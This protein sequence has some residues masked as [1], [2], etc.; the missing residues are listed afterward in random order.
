MVLAG[1]AGV[2]MGGNKPFQPHGGSTLIDR[3]IERLSPQVDGV[4]INAGAAGHPLSDALSE[5]GLPLVYDDA[6]WA[7][8]GPLS[9]VL[10]GLLAAQAANAEALITAPCD[11]PN[12]PPDMVAQLVAARRK[13]GAEIV[14]FRGERD[15]PLC[16]LWSVE[17]VPALRIALQTAKSQGGLSV[18]RFLQTQK[19]MTISVTD[20]LAFLNVNYLDKS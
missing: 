19:T 14:H 11:M 1:G 4:W 3:V 7:A 13:T 12:L 2:R 6:D 9:G 15:Y 16:A 20:E 10:S 5:L 8:L 18:F 17:V